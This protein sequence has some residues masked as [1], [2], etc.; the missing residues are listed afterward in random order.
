MLDE[1]WSG[2]IC[3]M[4]ESTLCNSAV[5]KLNNWWFI[6]SV[7]KMVMHY[8]RQNSRNKT[9]GNFLCHMTFRV[10]ALAMETLWKIAEIL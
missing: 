5:K 7:P 1:K 3:D 2:S 9:R 4:V 8:T 6:V 10:K